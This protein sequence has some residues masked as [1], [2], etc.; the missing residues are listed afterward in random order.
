MKIVSTLVLCLLA[1]LLAALDASCESAKEPAIS[2]G[3]PF[4]CSKP[5]EVTKRCLADDSEP[6]QTVMLINSSE[7]CLGKAGGADVGR[8][9]PA[10]QHSWMW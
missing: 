5:N 9:G 10:I 2:F 1:V 6:G 7:M 3:L 8:A 4:D